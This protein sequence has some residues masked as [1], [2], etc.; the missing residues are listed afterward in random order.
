MGS[1]GLWKGHPSRCEVQGFQTSLWAALLPVLWLVLPLFQLTK[2]LLSTYQTCQDDDLSFSLCLH[3]LGS[4][5]LG[6][7]LSTWQTSPLMEA[8]REPQA[9]ACPRGS[10][11]P[12]TD[13]HWISNRHSVNLGCLFQLED[14]Q[15]PSLTICESNYWKWSLAIE[16]YDI[17]LIL[18]IFG[19]CFYGFNQH[20]QKKIKEGWS[21]SSVV[22][23]LPSIMRPWVQSPA[24]LYVYIHMCIYN[25]HAFN[26]IYRYFITI[27]PLNIKIFV[28][29]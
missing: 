12:R 5:T 18:W 14:I 3:D 27:I 26:F 7:V 20:R 13:Q 29:A 15:K 10:L 25:V 21:Y 2:C 23:H 6:S 8:S 4:R 9:P 28:L 17:Q 1:D 22:K 16:C 11:S 24:P 19:F